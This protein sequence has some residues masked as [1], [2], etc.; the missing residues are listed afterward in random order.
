MLRWLR[1]LDAM[2]WASRHERRRYHEQLE[3]SRPFA[4]HGG[5]F[6]VQNILG[7]EWSRYD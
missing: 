7:T 3:R 2:V 5:W 1:N 6:L 4:L